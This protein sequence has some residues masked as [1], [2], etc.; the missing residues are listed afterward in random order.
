[1]LDSMS[2][3][4]IF[5]PNKSNTGHFFKFFIDPRFVGSEKLPVSVA[6]V[7]QDGFSNGVG[8][9]S[10]SLKNPKANCIVKLSIFEVS[11]I[12]SIIERVENFIS[13]GSLSEK[14]LEGL[15]L[16]IGA[17]NDPRFKA[18][19]I[20]KTEKSTTQIFFNV[21]Y[22]RK[23]FE[24]GSNCPKGYF[25]KIVKNAEEQITFLI[26]ITL[27]EGVLLK[28]F[29]EWSL[30]VGFENR[31]GGQ[32]YQNGQSDQESAPVN[33]EDEESLPQQA[34]PQKQEP[35]VHRPQ[36]A[37]QPSASSQKASLASLLKGAPKSAFPRSKFEND[38]PAKGE[39]SSQPVSEEEDPF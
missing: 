34:Q 2:S 12:I 32:N 19:F 36:T 6:A 39:V 28:K 38:P 4:A 15:I 29:L 33:E 18:K 37:P 14:M 21:N 31:S 22:S 1:M 3:L 16:S 11:E 5:K 17:E 25:L 10:K 35:Q 30:N 24:A 13:F 26:P 27:S 23:D 8:S 9:F 20:H 7:K